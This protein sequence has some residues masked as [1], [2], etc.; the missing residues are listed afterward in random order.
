MVSVVDR[1]VDLDVLM[2]ELLI[3]FK[4][5]DVLETIVLFSE[6]LDVDWVVKIVLV[7]FELVNVPEN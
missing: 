5:V 7:G 1:I 3:K 4:L 6:V 2:V